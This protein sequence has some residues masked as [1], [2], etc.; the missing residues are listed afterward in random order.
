MEVQMSMLL[1]IAATEHQCTAGVER[2]G[3]VGAVV[4]GAVCGSDSSGGVKCPLNELEGN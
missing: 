4:V 1:T 3:G 2:A